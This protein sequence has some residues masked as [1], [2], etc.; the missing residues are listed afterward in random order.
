MRSIV[1]DVEDMS[2]HVVD[3]YERIAMRIRNH[4]VLARRQSEIVANDRR[5]SRA[6]SPKSTQ[7]QPEKYNSQSVAHAY[8]ID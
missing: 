7:E 3:I 2:L 8:T 4:D 5:V 6:P 1:A